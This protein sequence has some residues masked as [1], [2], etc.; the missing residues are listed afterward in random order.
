MCAQGSSIGSCQNLTS[1]QSNRNGLYESSTRG[2]DENTVWMYELDSGCEH[3]T[4]APEIERYRKLEAERTGGQ[5]WAPAESDADPVRIAA[6]ILRRQ[7]EILSATETRQRSMA[8]ADHLGL[9]GGQWQDLIRE[10]SGDRFTA[11]VRDQ[12]PAELADKALAD[13]DDLFR[14]LRAAELTGLPGEQALAE[15]LAQRSL[16]GADSVP[17]VLASRVRGARRAAPP[18]TARIVR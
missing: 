16:E 5:P 12:L 8:N 7:D 11:A 1:S 17:A 4:P 3:G 6:G 13:T 10:L 2:R 9:L 14:A 18:A 15:A